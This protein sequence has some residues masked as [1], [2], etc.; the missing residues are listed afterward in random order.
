MNSYSFKWGKF[1]FLDSDIACVEYKDG[2][3][4]EVEDVMEFY[5]LF[6]KMAE[7][8]KLKLL[9]IP[10]KEMS[11]TK[12]AREFSQ[13]ARLNCGREAIIIYSLAQRIFT[14]FFI[15]F[16]NNAE[17]PIKMFNSKEEAIKWLRKI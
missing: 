10:T 9:V 12:S 2:C 7:S 8:K 3:N 6:N 1:F 5:A 13:S 4:V 11:A 17:Y 16:K 14:N 15:F